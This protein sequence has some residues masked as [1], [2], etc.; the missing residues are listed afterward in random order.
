MKAPAISWPTRDNWGSPRQPIHPD[1][2]L[3]QNLSSFATSTEIE[4]LVRA[5]Q[6]LHEQQSGVAKRR[7]TEAIRK[8]RE[9]KL[10]YVS[11]VREAQ[12]LLEPLRRRYQDA[13]E[14]HRQAWKQYR[15]ARP[16][17]DQAWQVELERR[18]AVEAEFAALWEAR[19]EAEESPAELVAAS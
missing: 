8:L 6:Q 1:G 9:D 14:L 13:T 4:A 18:A 3:P 2:K 5:L 10:P 11:E 12:K 7:I 15:D 19:E 16:V 17:D